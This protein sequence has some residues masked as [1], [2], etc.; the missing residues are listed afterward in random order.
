M[1]IWST[2]IFPDGY[3]DANGDWQRSKFCFV[4]CG[5]NCTCKPPNGIYH[6]NLPANTIISEINP[7][8][9]TIEPL[10]FERGEPYSYAATYNGITVVE[11]GYHKPNLIKRLREKL[12]RKVRE[13][14][15]L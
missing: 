1:S 12:E 5:S 7:E 10:P 15:M 9:I 14:D 3:Y 13:M 2:P 11:K 6:K 4:D 8:E